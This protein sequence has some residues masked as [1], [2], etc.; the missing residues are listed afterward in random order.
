MRSITLQAKITLSNILL[1]GR[2]KTK[3]FLDGLAFFL[4]MLALVV[5]GT[6]LVGLLVETVPNVHRS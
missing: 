2:D 5:G 6:F 1:Q 3:G 4:L